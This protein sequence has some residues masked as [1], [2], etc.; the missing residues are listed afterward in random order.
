MKVYKV[1]IIII[2]ILEIGTVNVFSTNA[3]TS[4]I[5]TPVV[6]E[7]QKIYD[8]ANLLTDEQETNLYNEVQEY[9]N[10]YQMDM[11]IVTIEENNKTS[12]MAYADDFYD[13]NNFGIGANKSGVL[14]LIDM[15]N[16][17]MWISTTGYA[18]RIYTDSRIDNILDYTYSKISIE[19]Y[20]GC[21]E[22]FIKYAKYYANLGSSASN[23]G[24][25]QSINGSTNYNKSKYNFL[26]FAKTPFIISLIATVV[27]IIIGLTSHKK[28]KKQQY[29]N[30]YI[31]SGI[32][33]NKQL[34][35]F[36]NQYVTKTKIETS[37]SGS[38]G[39][40]SSTHSGSSGRSH[41][42]GG[43]SF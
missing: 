28:P 6:D 2:C 24:S 29:A 12:A 13:Y 14:F 40:H 38:S 11:A 15:Q 10:S 31:S 34:D 1:F 30:L 9:I 41:G 4:Q 35:N 8:Y 5:N 18:I 23:T 32:K 43:R 37:S 39:G 25:S 33:L 7:N 26:Y 16:R 36:V 21:V 3:S 20:N 19:D 27:F 17:E 42:G 22:Q